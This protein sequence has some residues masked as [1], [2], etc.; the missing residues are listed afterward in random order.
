MC[1]KGT[2]LEARHLGVL[3]S[4]G[5]EQVEVYRR[6]KVAIA[7][8]GSELVNPGQALKAGQIYNSTV[9]C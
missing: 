2:K 6:L 8:T 1:D 3:A 7:S 4:M 5:I 9:S